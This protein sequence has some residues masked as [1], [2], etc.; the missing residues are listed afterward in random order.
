MATPHAQPAAD[1][2]GASAARLVLPRRFVHHSGCV[3]QEA[4]LHELQVALLLESEDAYT[5]CLGSRTRV[6][7]FAAQ[8]LRELGV[9]ALADA[10][11][12]Y[13]A[14]SGAERQRAVSAALSETDALLARLHPLNLHQRAAR[15]LASGADAP[16]LADLLTEV[17]PL[18]TRAQS[19]V[20]LT[21]ALRTQPGWR[22]ALAPELASA[23]FSALEAFVREERA[24][25]A[26]YPPPG[27][28]FEALNACP[29]RSVRVIIVGQDPYHAAGQA[30][31]LAFSVDAGTAVPSSLRNILK[32]LQADV[33]VAAPQDGGASLRAWAARGVLLLNT[34]L[35]VRAGAPGSH[36]GRGWERVSDA[37][38]AAAC[39]QRD[40]LVLLLWGRHAAAKAAL[41][42]PGRGHVVLTAAHPS[43]LSAHRGFFGARPFSRANEALAASGAPPLDWR[44]P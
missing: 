8:R 22:A 19:C 26:V 31:G 7:A 32:E 21:P 4:A 1:A 34:A 23:S 40:G 28:V 37:A 15:Q 25:H 9:G 39:S 14:L 16:P 10:F 36:A 20:L 17:L 11:A 38:I 41:V 5:D 33:G 43:G 12:R 6:S 44:L 30:C 2:A 29:L 13:G 24:C 3:A 18:C 35:T 27:S 42:P